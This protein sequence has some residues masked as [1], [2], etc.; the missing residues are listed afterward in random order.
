MEND[1]DL[2]SRIKNF[3][4][5]L[6]RELDERERCLEREWENEKRFGHHTETIK[7]YQVGVD[8]YRFVFHN[9]EKYFPESK[10]E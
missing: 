2:L 10:G 3:S 6:K 7:T 8:V 9:F 4:K 1:T 5:D